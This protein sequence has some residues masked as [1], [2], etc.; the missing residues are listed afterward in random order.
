[1][2]S[3]RADR[4][5]RD[6]AVAGQHDDANAIGAQRLQRG[7]RAL[8]DRIGDGDEAGGLPIDGDQHDALAVLAAAHRLWP[9]KSLGID[10]E[11]CEQ[12]QIADRDT[13]AIDGADD[14]LAG[15][16]RESRRPQRAQDRAPRH[17]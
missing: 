7:D 8:L 17:L 4:R 14:A 1:M 6:A 16:R 2:P 13:L 9:G 5:R 11:R 3:L 12:R 10:A 15:F